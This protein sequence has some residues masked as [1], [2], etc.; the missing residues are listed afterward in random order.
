MSRA[1][2]HVSIDED[3]LER[4][5]RMVDEGFSKS[6]IVRRTLAYGIDPMEEAINRLTGGTFIPKNGKEHLK[7]AGG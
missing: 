3:L 4:I 6:D 7:P 2:I 5:E 1:T